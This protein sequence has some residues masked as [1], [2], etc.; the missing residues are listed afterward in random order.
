VSVLFSPFRLRDV[1][2]RNRVFVSPMCQYSSRDGFPTD[3]HL[4]HLG[5]RAVGGAGLVMTEA[6]A[7]SPEGRISPDDAGL[8]ADDQARA[9]APIAHFIRDQGA[10]PAIQ[11]AH[12]GRTPPPEGPGAGGAPLRE[13]E[14]GWRPVGP[15]PV[16]FDTAHATPHE[17][18]PSGIAAIIDQF[19]AAARRAGSAGF[20]VIELHMA[21]GY[22]VHEFLSPLSN[23][24]SDQWGGGL[25]NRMRLAVAVAAAV[26]AVWPAGRPLLARISA[27]DWVEGGWDVEQSIALARRL[28]ETGVDLIDVSS[29]GNVAGARIPAAPGFQ[30]PFAAAL[31]RATGLPTGAVGLITEPAQAEEI[32]TSGQADVVLLARELLRHPYWPLH[33]AHA[34]GAD[35]E[36]PK[37]YLRARP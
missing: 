8:W 17:L 25:D 6:T 15:S 16:P 9:Y 27:T 37:Q 30:A 7:V 33:A 34:L 10:V 23:R 31:R 22:L 4:V 18:S 5:S 3:W 14:R 29:G 28:A 24:R 19:A 11:L 1:S 12:A 2:F 20:E 36:W 13:G 26:R 21:H 35:I 32:V